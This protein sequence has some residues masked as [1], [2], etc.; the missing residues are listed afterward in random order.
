MIKFSQIDKKAAEVQIN[1]AA[2]DESPM[3]RGGAGLNN[4]VFK[5]ARRW[6]NGAG[7][8]LGATAGSLKTA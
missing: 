7:L 3:G 2:K 4:F 8:K 5:K 6:Q 1:L